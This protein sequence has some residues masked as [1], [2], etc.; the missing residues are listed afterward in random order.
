MMN[1]AHIQSD[2]LTAT[3]LRTD[4]IFILRVHTA[5]AQLFLQLLLTSLYLV[6][7]ISVKRLQVIE[8]HLFVRV[9]VPRHYPFPGLWGSGSG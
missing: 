5:A 7:L 1:A 9:C 4:Q 2:R 8:V 3:T 6:V